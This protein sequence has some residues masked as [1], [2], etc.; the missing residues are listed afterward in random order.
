MHAFKSQQDNQTCTMLP[1]N[2]Q[3]FSTLAWC[4]PNFLLAATQ[5]PLAL[6]GS[7]AFSLIFLISLLFSLKDNARMM[8]L[9]FLFFFFCFIFLSLTLPHLMKWN[10]FH[11]PFFLFLLCH[12]SLLACNKYFSFYYLLPMPISITINK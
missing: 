3:L 1:A 5:I 4:Y 9:Q 2:P 12:M 10:F 6:L 8:S 11:F 7:L